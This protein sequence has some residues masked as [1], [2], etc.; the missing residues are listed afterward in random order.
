MHCA[1]SCV[2][3]ANRIHTRNT[4]MHLQQLSPAPTYPK[5]NNWR[6][7]I[8]RNSTIQL[9]NPNLIQMSVMIF[10]ALMRHLPV[11][12]FPVPLVC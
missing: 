1:S 10:L 9:T 7:R 2:L 11:T 6:N 8:K 3:S 4:H 12:P 5:R